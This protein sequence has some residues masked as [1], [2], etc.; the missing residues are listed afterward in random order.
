MRGRTTARLHLLPAKEAPVVVIVSRK[1]SKTFHIVIW[2]TETDAMEHGSWF[3]GHLYAKRSDVSFDGK[4]MVYLAMGADGNTWNGCCKLPFLKTHLEEENI[5]T[6]NGGGFWKDRETLLL[7]QWLNAKGSIPFKTEPLN[8]GQGEDLGV[9]YPRMERDGWQRLGDNWGTEREV[10]GS[11]YRVLCEGDDGWVFRHPV[12]RM[13][14]ETRYV[15]YL[16]YGYTFAFKLREY[17]ELIP[18]SAD[19]ATWDS[20]GNLV[21]AHDGE[22]H[23]YSKANILAGQL[24]FKFDLNQL[25]KPESGQLPD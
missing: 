15:G 3:K 16:D 25:K 12:T 18:V 1:P 20:I 7:N 13:N 19:W 2:N 17:P 14:L 5:G 21:V 11:K 10:S 4:W 22:V 9:L 8:A 23:R 24:G 6:W